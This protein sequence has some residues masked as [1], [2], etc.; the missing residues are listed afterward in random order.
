MNNAE[1]FLGMSL[2]SWEIFSSIVVDD[3]VG[4]RLFSH[5]WISISIS[6]CASKLIFLMSFKVV[7]NF[8]GWAELLHLC[9]NNSAEVSNSFI[10]KSLAILSNFFLLHCWTKFPKKS[11]GFSDRK[12]FAALNLEWMETR[13]SQWKLEGFFG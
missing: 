3:G 8:L 5:S 1:F 12:S 4:K 6:N 13:R 7:E 2:R 11:S 10:V 9:S